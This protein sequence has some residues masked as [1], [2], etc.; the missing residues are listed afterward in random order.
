VL[1]PAPPMTTASE[2]RTRGPDDLSDDL[3][4]W[5]DFL[6]TMRGASSVGYVGVEGDGGGMCEVESARR[7]RPVPGE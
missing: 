3:T 4:G 7:P 5:P 1:P 6:R 2:P